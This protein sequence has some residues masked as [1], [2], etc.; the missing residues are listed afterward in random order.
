MLF[1]NEFDA[2]P[3]KQV[4]Q[5]ENQPKGYARGLYHALRELDRAAHAQIVVEDLPVDSAW[6]AVRD[7]LKRAIVGSNEGK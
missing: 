1:S 2:T 3:F 7:R 4:I 6:D 5:L